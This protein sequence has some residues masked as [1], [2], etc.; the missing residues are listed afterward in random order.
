[1]LFLKDTD[2]DDKADLVVHLLDGWATDDTHHTCGA[3]EWNNAGLLHALE[4]IATSTTLET[5]WGPHRSAGTGGAY[6]MDPRTLKIRQFAL[7]GQYNM[8]CYVFDEWGQ[9]IVGDGTTANHHWDTPLSGAQFS[10]RKGLETVFNQ[11]G[12]RPALGCEW[13]VSRHFPDDVQKQ[14]TYACVIN[15]NGMPRF[16]IGDDGSGFKGQRVKKDNKADDL[17]K[18]TD[19]HFRPADPQIGPDG[20]LW[21]GDWANALVGHMQYSQ[22]D[23]SRDHV[24]GRIYRLVAK[25]RPLLKPVT[26]FGKSSAEILEQ[27]REPEWR[28]RYRARRELHDRPVTEVKPAVVAWLSSLKADDKEYDRLRCE[29]MWVLAGH[30][31]VEP[32]QIKSL[33]GAQ[34]PQARAAAVRVLSDER[35]RMPEALSWFKAAASD[36]NDRVKLEAARAL[37][38]YPSADAMAAVLDIAKGPMDKWLKYTV[39]HS[40]AANE[41]SWRSDFLAGRLGKGNEAGQKVLLEIL[42]SSKAGN[43][44]VPFLRTLLSQEETSK[45]TRNKA[46][47]ALTALKGNSNKGREV[48]VRACT[49]CHKVGN[50]EGNEF[51]P[52]LHQVAT[53]LKDRYKLVES[54]IDPNAEV[55]KKYLSTRI[56][57]S[58]GKIYSGLVI[59]EN[60]KEVVLFDGKEK[61]AIPVADIEERVQLKQ[62]SMPEGLAGAMAPVEFLD[63]MEYLATL[64]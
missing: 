41:A 54:V 21:F 14:F 8:W 51:G 62:S 40:L 15:M 60:P 57:T 11:E 25:G 34:T 28:T 4:G 22:R 42:A 37:S 59:S 20:A 6:V 31:A 7:P 36:K 19:K 29:A 9:G 58:Q 10:G 23:P 5:P 44:A 64:K 48:F 50:G 38:L 45:E 32:D 63:L 30:H 52:N 56:A 3:F 39:E 53:R 47:T 26:Q 24:R 55:D 12:M 43:A 17:I 35:D 2:G 13:L 49:A 16:T 33:L 18:S 1:M 61:R 46:M 27:L